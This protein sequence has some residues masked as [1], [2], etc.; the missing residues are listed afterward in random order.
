LELSRE[1]LNGRIPRHGSELIIQITA[2][3]IN[4]S[5]AGVRYVV[6]ARD[7]P[8]GPEESRTIG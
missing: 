3:L 7:Y 4:I 6:V 5:P 2:A 1:H 8:V